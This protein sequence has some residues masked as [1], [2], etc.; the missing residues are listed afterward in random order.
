VYFNFTVR[1][2]TLRSAFDTV[3]LYGDVSFTPDP[4][5]TLLSPSLY[6]VILVRDY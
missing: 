4:S 5:N 2:E 6:S 3:V 1:S